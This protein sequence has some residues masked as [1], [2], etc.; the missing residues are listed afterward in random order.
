MIALT[1]DIQPMLSM[2]FSLQL[3]VMN[4]F[5]KCLP[6]QDGDP[7]DDH[8]QDPRNGSGISHFLPIVKIV[9]DVIHDR[10]GRSIRSPT[11]HDVRLVKT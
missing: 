10:S 8:K 9:K 3:L 2:V 7:E 6:L 5:S 4:P 1:F 11:R